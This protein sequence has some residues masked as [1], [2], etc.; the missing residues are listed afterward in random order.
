MW[1]TWTSAPGARALDPYFQRCA[2]APS[3]DRRRLD[4]V[5]PS[6]KGAGWTC[7]SATALPMMRPTVETDSWSPWRSRMALSPGG[8]CA[9]RAQV[10]SRGRG[11]AAHLQPDTGS[12]TCGGRCRR[13]PWSCR[14]EAKRLEVAD[15]NPTAVGS[16]WVAVA[17]DEAVWSAEALGRG[18]E[19]LPEAGTRE[20][21]DDFSSLIGV[22]RWTGW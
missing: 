20:W 2:Q 1:S 9:P 13:E 22:V 10:A 19:R 17:R 6:Q 3:K 7:L 11:P 8:H 14:L 5:R 12:S 4:L 16:H 21:R 18:W 15:R